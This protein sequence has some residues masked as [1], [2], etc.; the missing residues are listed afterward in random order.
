VKLDRRY[1]VTRS[2]AFM[3]TGLNKRHSAQD[4]L[5]YGVSSFSVSNAILWWHFLHEM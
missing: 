2:L 1:F 3:T 4:L 5:A